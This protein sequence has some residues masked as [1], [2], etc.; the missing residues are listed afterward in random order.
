[1]ESTGRLLVV[2]LVTCYLLGRI[3]SGAAAPLEVV[4]YG[5]TAAFGL[6]YLVSSWGGLWQ[7][8]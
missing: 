7:R 4:V 6:E 2:G 8:T 1:M 3:F 5:M